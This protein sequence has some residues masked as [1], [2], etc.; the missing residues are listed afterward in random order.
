MKLFI[1]L[2][3]LMFAVGAFAYLPVGAQGTCVD[4]KVIQQNGQELSKNA[5]A[6]E[7]KNQFVLLEFVS[8]TCSYCIRSL[9]TIAKFTNEMIGDLTIR[10]IGV[11]RNPELLREY[12]KN[13]QQHMVFDLALDNA[14]VMKVAYQ[15]TAVPTFFLL[16]SKK[17]IV[18]VNEGTLQPEHFEKIRQ[19]VRA[20]LEN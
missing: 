16:D 15:V 1:C 6:S 14:R 4:L 19:L 18:F 9:P 12:W 17:T 13:H 10:Q 7:N 11:D 5:C 20:P 3:T 2:F 8:A